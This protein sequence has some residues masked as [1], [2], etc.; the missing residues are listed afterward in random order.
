MYLWCCEE[1]HDFEFVLNAAA[2]RTM[3]VDD[4]RIIIPY[5]STLSMSEIFNLS[6]AHRPI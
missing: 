3:Y 4:L 5:Y 1:Y 6:R 2:F